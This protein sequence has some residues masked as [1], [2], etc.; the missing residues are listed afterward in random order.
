ME[1]FMN[2]KIILSL[3]VLLSFTYNSFAASGFSHSWP[4]EELA[5]QP[6]TQEE[7]NSVIDMPSDDE[8]EEKDA[9]KALED[10]ELLLALANGTRNPSANPLECVTCKKVFFSKKNLT[11]HTRIH[12]DERPYKCHLCPKT[13]IESNL[14]RR[15]S[16]IHTGLKPY[17]CELCNV[18][19]YYKRCFRSHQ[20]TSY[21]Q[22]QLLRLQRQAISAQ[23]PDDAPPPPKC[24]ICNVIVSGDFDVH[25]AQHTYPTHSS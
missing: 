19:F 18:D 24:L 20:R 23:T 21:H 11:R 25:M 14:L 4:T 8:P 13:F 17:K 12:T 16:I 5:D 1:Y 6:E 2:K 15:H 10:A 22:D 7:E 9:K 3:L